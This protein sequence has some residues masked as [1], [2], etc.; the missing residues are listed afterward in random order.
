MTPPE[1]EQNTEDMMLVALTNRILKLREDLNEL[2]QD[3]LDLVNLLERSRATA[4]QREQLEERIRRLEKR[5]FPQGI[6]EGDGSDT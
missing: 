2:T 5:I 4:H 6:P 3:Y 1:D